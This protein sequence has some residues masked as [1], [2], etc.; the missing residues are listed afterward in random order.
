MVFVGLVMQYFGEKAQ[1]HFLKFMVGICTFAI[2]CGVAYKLNWFAILDP[3]EPASENSILL[4]TLA[5]ALA[6]I[7]TLVVRWAFKKTLRLAPTVIGL[8]AGYW[9]SIYLI[10]AIN[11]IGGLFVTIP[12]AAGSSADVIGPWSGALIELS[13]SALGALVGYNFSLVFVLTI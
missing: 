13:M 2:V 10:V 8:F 9:F 6:I 7:A 1:R 3:T 12:S 4:T 5:F 11:G